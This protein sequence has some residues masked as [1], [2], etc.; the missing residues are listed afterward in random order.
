MLPGQVTVMNEGG[1]TSAGS[2]SADTRIDWG[3]CVLLVLASLIL[4]YLV[5]AFTIIIRWMH[6][7]MRGP[8]F[9]PYLGVFLTTLALVLLWW[10]RRHHNGPLP[11]LS[12]SMYSVVAG[13]VAGI[14]ALVL[15][16][17]FQPDGLQQVVNS[18]RFPT[19]EAAI[20]FLWFPIRLLTWIYGGI[21]GL[22]LVMLSRR[23]RL[24]QRTT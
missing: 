15:Y 8:Y 23:F 22:M 3:R 6:F 12:T 11:L 21:A 4:T 16:P 10:T 2:L 18:L 14:V 17:M 13:Y 1:N 24:F 9:V 7:W 19:I 20:A 5:A